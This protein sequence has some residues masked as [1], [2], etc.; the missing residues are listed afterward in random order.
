MSA[1]E[2]EQGSDLPPED[3]KVRASYAM[4]TD[5]LH[6]REVAPSSRYHGIT[7]ESLFIAAIAPLLH[8]LDTFIAGTPRS[9]H[10]PSRPAL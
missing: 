10:R 1:Q 8:D 7:S 6:V 9:G 4:R 2:F 5:P 3:T